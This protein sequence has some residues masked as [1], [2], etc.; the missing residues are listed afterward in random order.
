VRVLS[1][2][3]IVLSMLVFGTTSQAQP[4]KPHPHPPHSKH[5]VQV[6][7]TDPS[8]IPGLQGAQAGAA[9]QALGSYLDGIAQANLAIY[10]AAVHDAEVAA[11]AA[12]RPPSTPSYTSTGGGHSDAW[13]SGVAM[14]EQGGRN[15]PYFGYF[16]FMDGSQGGKPWAEQVAAGNALLASA[17]REVGPWAASCVA[18][19]YAA[20]P[21]G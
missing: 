18:A 19:G 8:S 16:S 6:T 7:P 13:W 10:L 12:A 4:D 11:A 2:C 21:G 9:V 17:G 1:T 20:S 3:L 15:D 5:Q 14:C